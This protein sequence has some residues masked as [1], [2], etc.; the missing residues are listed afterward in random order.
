MISKPIRF[1]NDTFKVNFYRFNPDSTD[2]FDDGCMDIEIRADKT[3]AIISK[4]T[5]NRLCFR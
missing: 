3:G 2:P 1:E 4:D 5:V